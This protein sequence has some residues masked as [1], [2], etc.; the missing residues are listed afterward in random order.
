MS[1]TILASP[2]E[3][4]GRRWPSG[5][6]PHHGIW[7]Y[8]GQIGMGAPGRRPFP[9]GHYHPTF[10]YPIALHWSDWTEGALIQKRTMPRSPE[11]AS[12]WLSYLC[13][14]IEGSLAAGHAHVENLL[15]SQLFLFLTGPLTLQQM[16]FNRCSWCYFGISSELFAGFVTTGGRTFAVTFN[17]RYVPMALSV[18]EGAEWIHIR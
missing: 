9:P 10:L 3:L 15:S 18:D 12:S 14:F 4:G 8:P 1:S 5:F 6:E 7:G 16:H 13:P 2:P 17:T 11:L